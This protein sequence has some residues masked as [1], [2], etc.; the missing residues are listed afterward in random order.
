M[1]ADVDPVLHNTAYGETP[2]AAETEAIPFD[3]P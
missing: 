1:I 2:P 3:V